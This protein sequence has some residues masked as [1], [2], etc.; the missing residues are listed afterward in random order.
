MSAGGCAEIRLSLGAYVLGALDPA[1]RS[2]VDAHLATCAECRDELASLAGLPGLLGRV[3]RAEV[4]D[5]PSDPGPQLLDRLLNAAATQRRQDRRRRWLTSVAAAVIALAGI[6]VAIG[7]GQDRHQTVSATKPPA[8]V[9]ETFTATNPQTHVQAS[10]TEWKKGWGASLQVTVT[11]V[12]AELAGARCQ[13]IAVGP[14][15]KTDVAASW[16]APS[17][18]YTGT[19]KVDA[20]GATALASSD[21]TAF[22]VVGSDGATLVWVPAVWTT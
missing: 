17:E 8:G 19:S 11:G 21:I 13:L 2:R 16:A 15:G 4:E 20:N 7:V 14:G 1:D 3:S 5:E 10:V 9:S 22:K 18:G 12:T 6:G